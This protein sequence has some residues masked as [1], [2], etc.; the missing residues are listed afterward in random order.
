MSIERD[1]PLMEP[2]Q[3]TPQ[4]LSLQLMR[5][6]EQGGELPDDVTTWLH[7]GLARWSGGDCASLEHALGLCAPGIASPHLRYAQ[8]LRDDALRRAYG[9]IEGETVKDRCEQLAAKIRAFEGRSIWRRYRE[10]REPPA[11]LDAVQ[12]ELFAAFKAQI[13]VPRSYSQLR[14]I[15]SRNTP[16]S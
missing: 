6:L 8:Q 7:D 13:D 15:I 2:K 12:R 16:F 1:V 4:T 5:A 14:R 10:L 11:H 9:L 3:P